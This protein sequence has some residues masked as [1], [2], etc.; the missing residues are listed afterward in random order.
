M[1]IKKIVHI[2]DFQYI[3][4]NPTSSKNTDM[5]DLKVIK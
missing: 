3:K 1:E 4:K 5:H 2:I